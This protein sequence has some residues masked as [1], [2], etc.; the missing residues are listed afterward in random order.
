MYVILLFTQTK[1]FK[2]CP[3]ESEKISL[4]SYM[5]I[6]E[7]KNILASL[8]YYVKITMTKQFS[9]SHS[10]NAISKAPL[11]VYIYVLFIIYLLYIYMY[12]YNSKMKN[13]H[14]KLKN[15]INISVMVYSK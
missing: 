1:N 7:L 15:L 11:Y 4:I 13:I 5:E 8:Q 2:L 10:L 3:K 14:K 9:K 6:Y 12:I